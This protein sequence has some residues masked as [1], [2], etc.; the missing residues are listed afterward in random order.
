MHN[1]ERMFRHL[2]RVIRT[3]F[4][5]YLS[6]P[7]DVAELYQNILPYRHH[8]RELGLETNED[9]EITM[10][11]L[12][13]GSHGYVIVDDRMREA[14]R[15]ELTS[16]NPDPG[17]FRQFPDAQVTLSQTAIQ[18]LDATPSAPP[19]AERGAPAAAAAAPRAT[20]APE[21]AAPARNTQTGSAPAAARTDRPSAAEGTSSRPAPVP[22]RGDGTITPGADEH[23]RACNELLPAGRAITFCPHCGENLTRVNCPACGSEL[24]LGWR[25]CPVCGRPAA[26]H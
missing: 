11:E 23:C 20:N 15:T 12:L 22:P 14:L 10:L 21:T 6:Q 17:A 16:R 18:Q 25:F 3:R 19:A 26:A 2:V 7:F 24:E 5:Q 9:Y 1:V 8:R 4:P 13:G